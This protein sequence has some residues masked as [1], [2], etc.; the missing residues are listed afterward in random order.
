MRGSPRRSPLKSRF[1][2][3]LHMTLVVLVTMAVFTPATAQAA[4]VSACGGCQMSGMAAAPSD[5]G[6][7]GCSMSSEGS[8]PDSCCSVPVSS[9]R[10][11][12][13]D[14]AGDTSRSTVAVQPGEG[15]A[16]TFTVAAIPAATPPLTSAGP[17][18]LQAPAHPPGGVA[19]GT[20]LRVGQALSGR[21]DRHRGPLGLRGVT[22]RRVRAHFPRPVSSARARDRAPRLGSPSDSVIRKR[23]RRT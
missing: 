17:A 15:P 12:S 14:H 10:M 8:A 2:K 19:D 21:G 11:S 18:A 7:T 20:R 9:S 16:F 22:P 4:C 13:C 3:T 6:M 23:V 1:A 5:H